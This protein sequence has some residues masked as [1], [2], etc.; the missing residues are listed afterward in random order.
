MKL[1]KKVKKI[2]QRNKKISPVN[3]NIFFARVGQLEQENKLLRD[4]NIGLKFENKK[5]KESH[6]MGE[7]AC[8]PRD[9]ISSFQ[10]KVPHHNVS[11]Q[12]ST[13]QR[14]QVNSNETQSRH[15]NNEADG[16]WKVQSPKF[17][18]RAPGE[19]M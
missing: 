4:E 12:N 16:E 14:H 6:S 15:T 10:Y 9:P 8:R 13:A 3:F 7:V 19:Q 11:K 18:E 2:P 17:S 5:L 1:Q